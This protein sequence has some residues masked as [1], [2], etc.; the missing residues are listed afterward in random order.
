MEL[1]K[2]KNLQAK[3]RNYGKIYKISNTLKVFF[4][5]LKL[6]LLC[7][8]RESRKKLI[9]L[10]NLYFIDK[11]SEKKKTFIFQVTFCLAAL[12]L[13]FYIH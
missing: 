6:F 9:Y 11:S 2:V 8:P 1:E 10:A 5:I 3:D 13:P 7:K 4:F 12:K